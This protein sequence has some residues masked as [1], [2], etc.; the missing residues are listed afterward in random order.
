MTLTTDDLAASA[1]YSVDL[2]QRLQDPSGAYPASPTFSAY[3]G[4]SWFRDG[5]FIADAMSAARAGGSAEAFFDWCARMLVQRRDRVEHIVAAARKGSPVPDSEMLDT[6]FTF[7]GRPGDAEWWDFQLDGYGTWLWAAAQHA[8]RTGGNLER[9]REGVELSVDYLVSS[10]QRPCYD[11]WEEHTDRVHVSTLGCIAAGLGAVGTYLDATRAAAAAAA[12]AAIR[13]RIAEDG[14]AEGHLAKWLGSDRV[15][16]SL[17]A[18]I[19]PLRFIPAGSAVGMA[20]IAAIANALEI[21]DG[22][23]R[24]ADDTYFG[25]GQWPLLSCMLGL[26]R[27]DA[28]D[29]DG[30]LR[31]LRWA[32]STATATGDLPEQ[33]D[34]HL[35]HPEHE[36]EWVQRWGPSAVPLLWT[37][38][39]VLRLA[40]E[41]GVDGVLDG[42]A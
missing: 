27:S 11:W 35:L 36:Q 20:T 3:L 4:F 13:E 15:D 26:A 40:V 29:H 25:G 18:L 31:S 12:V 19:S 30:A 38:A 23:H 41:L 7:D 6:R 37:H 5:A 2:I 34:W 17:L 33:V 39:M 42:A 16:A 24:Y 22:V 8:T 28:G 21:D 14:T 32:A 1:R 10:W 9:W